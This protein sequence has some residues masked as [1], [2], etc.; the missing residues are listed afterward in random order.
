MLELLDLKVALK[1]PVKVVQH[2]EIK[3]SRYALAVVVSP[4]QNLW[5]FFE[6][7]SEEKIVPRI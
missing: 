5:V 7:D 1:A 6:I 4:M 2:V 3:V